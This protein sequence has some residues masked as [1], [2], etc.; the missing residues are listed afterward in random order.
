MTN[1]IFD[2]DVIQDLKDKLEYLIQSSQKFESE[3]L[4]RLLRQKKGILDDKEKIVFKHI[5]KHP[6]KS[7]Q[8]IVNDLYGIKSRGPIFK[9]IPNLIRYEMVVQRPDNTNLQIHR[10]YVNKV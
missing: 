6:G 3:D 4:K 7:K 10:L 2:L 9:A 5:R 8:D 1:V